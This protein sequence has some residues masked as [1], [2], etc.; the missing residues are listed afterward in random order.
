MPE[1]PAGSHRQ[2]NLF[3]FL[4]M[5]AWVGCSIAYVPFLTVL[6]PARV[7]DLA[8]ND[9]VTWLAYISFTGAIVASLANIGFGWLSDITRN[10]R[11]I[12]T[13]G[14]VLSSLML[15]ISGPI[16]TLAAF[17]VVI[18]IWQFALNMMLAPLA[19]WAGDNVP[20]HQ[21]GQLGGLMSVAPAAG[22]ISGAIV[23]IPG[24]ASGE[25]RLWFVAF[26]VVLCVA[27]A[28]IAG[29]PKRFPELLEDSTDQKTRN[30][31]IRV[32]AGL[33]PRMWIARFLIQVAEAAL[34]AYL[35][36][37]F[38]S[39]SESFSDNDIAKVY[40]FV[41]VAGI[42]IAL[43]AGRWADRRNRP[44]VLLVVCAA[45]ISMGLL[46]MATASGLASGVFGYV[47]FGVAGTVFLSL[48]SAQTLRVLPRPEK[49]GRDLGL[50][51]LTNTMPTLIMPWLTLAIFPVFGFSG[52]IAL[53][54]FLAFI[55]FVILLTAPVE[56]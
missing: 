42:P 40:S 1:P 56:A 9:A 54:A 18:S 29:R 8:G 26:I 49:R 50:F 41:L 16:E 28:L 27:P 37:W 21:K 12:A 47:V 10:R 39:L 33:V 46:I 52:L 53:L 34:F 2:N 17:L 31:H 51:N 3:M 30:G 22:A 45:I 38:R 36:L 48:H 11:G 32:I 7:A 43:L 35:L 6:L 44:M 20:D 23:T 25:A 55:S 14:L 5:I 15:V 24:F 4:Y 19:A 13:A